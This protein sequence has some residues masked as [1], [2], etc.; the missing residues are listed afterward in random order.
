MGERNENS[1]INLSEDFS[2]LATRIDAWGDFLGVQSLAQLYELSTKS[3][4]V[5]QRDWES[6]AMN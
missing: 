2:M 6:A 4:F 1:I 5:P 3:V